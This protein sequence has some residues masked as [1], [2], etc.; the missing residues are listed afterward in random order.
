V[1]LLASSSSSSPYEALRSDGEAPLASCGPHPFWLRVRVGVCVGIGVRTTLE[2]P[3]NAVGM[4]RAAWRR[5]VRMCVLA[6]A[7]AYAKPRRAFRGVSVSARCRRHSGVHVGATTRTGA[8]TLG[9]AKCNCASP[10]VY[11]G[12]V[13]RAVSLCGYH[14]YVSFVAARGGSQTSSDLW[15]VTITKHCCPSGSYECCRVSTDDRS[16]HVAAVRSQRRAQ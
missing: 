16:L 12:P 4:H 5:W 14:D 15:E 10:S 7:S 9:T 3:H 1:C 8:R 2:K 13:G 6:A 11:R